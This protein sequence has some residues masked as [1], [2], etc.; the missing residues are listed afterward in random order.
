MSP[1]KY[2]TD[3]ERHE[4]YKKQQNNY[5]KKSGFAKHVT[6]RLAKAIKLNICAVNSI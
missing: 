5:C 1:R 6:I 3:E 4:A 2:L